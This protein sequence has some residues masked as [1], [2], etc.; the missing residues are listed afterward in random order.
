MRNP[1]RRKCCEVPLLVGDDKPGS[2]VEGILRVG[3][4]WV[5]FTGVVIGP[6][7]EDRRDQ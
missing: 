6:D 5:D 3:G 7:E 2:E 1:F 4:T